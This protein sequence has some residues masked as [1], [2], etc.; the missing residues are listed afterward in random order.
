MSRL[1]LPGALVLSTAVTVLTAACTKA[2]GVQ[3]SHSPPDSTSIHVITALPCST[4]D[5]FVFR[6][7]LLRECIYHKRTGQEPFIRLPTSESDYIAAGIADA[8]GVFPDDA[9]VTF[10]E[11]SSVGM[12]YAADNPE[13]PLQ[14]G[15]AYYSGQAGAELNLTP[16][17]CRIRIVSIKGNSIGMLGDASLWLE[18]ISNGCP[19]MQTDGF[20]P[21]VTISTP[22]GLKDPAMMIQAVPFDIG[23]TAH[24]CDIRLWCYP[25]ESE[26]APSRI[27]L[28][29]KVGTLFRSFS[30]P[31][32]P[33]G[34]GAKLTAA[35]ELEDDGSLIL[36]RKEWQ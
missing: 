34:R 13:Q 22:E 11:I 30:T 6:D 25:N 1:L 26:S 35:L 36:L 32:P 5:I 7:T 17:L 28:G 24:E 16:L 20:H 19:I 4:L 33:L 23:S 8:G 14:S 15:I 31:L 21:S 2:P 18:N 10:S 9:F 3:D 29:G 27:C 12:E